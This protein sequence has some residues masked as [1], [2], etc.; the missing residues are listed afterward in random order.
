MRH[1]RLIETGQTADV[2]GGPREDY[3]K[4]LVADLVPIQRPL[5]HHWKQ[6][7]VRFG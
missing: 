2:L 1:G 4:A 5:Q 3:T 6:S 7:C